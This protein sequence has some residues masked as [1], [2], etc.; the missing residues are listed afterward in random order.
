MA[1]VDSSG[2]VFFFDSNFLQLFGVDPG[3]PKFL[4]IV[5]LTQDSA[6]LIADV[7]PFNNAVKYSNIIN[8][9]QDSASLIADVLPV[10]NAV[11]YSNIINL[12][13]PSEVT[14]AGDNT[15]SQVWVG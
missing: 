5:N 13:V 10:S 7:L 1:I 6:S 14:I 4:N 2:F 12:A 11:K 15:P 3:G 9:T 8:L